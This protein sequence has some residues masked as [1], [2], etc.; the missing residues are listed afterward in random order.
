MTPPTRWQSTESNRLSVDFS[1]YHKDTIDYWKRYWVNTKQTQLY[2]LNYHRN[3]GFRSRRTLPHTAKSVKNNIWSRIAP[4]LNPPAYGS[5]PSIKSIYP[6][7]LSRYPPTPIDFF[8]VFLKFV[9]LVFFFYLLENTNCM[10][11]K[12]LC[13][14]VNASLQRLMWH[15]LSFHCLINL[16]IQI[17]NSVD[18]CSIV[19]RIAELPFYPLFSCLSSTPYSHTKSIF[20]KTTTTHISTTFSPYY[21]ISRIRLNDSSSFFIRFFFLNYTHFYC[22]IFLIFIYLYFFLIG[23]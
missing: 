23:K 20:I 1:S 6:I 4:F 2:I 18:D 17:W 12:Q 7:L 11:I 22:N 15:P 3:G 14:L 19:N 16:R 10:Q 13:G 21:S 9:F 5:I 8:V